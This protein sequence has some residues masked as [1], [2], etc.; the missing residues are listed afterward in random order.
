M[1][2]CGYL[3]VNTKAVSTLDFPEISPAS[4]LLWVQCAPIVAIVAA[5]DQSQPR[6]HR[7]ENASE[8]WCPVYAGATTTALTRGVA[9]VIVQEQ[10]FLNKKKK[11]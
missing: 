3:R 1:D 5:L 11:V 7:G 2:K 10:R 4:A 6:H 8:C 9:P